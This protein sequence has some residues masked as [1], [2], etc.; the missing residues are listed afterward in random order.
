MSSRL[1]QVTTLCEDCGRPKSTTYA[2]LNDGECGAHD[3]PHFLLGLAIV[4]CAEI[5]EQRKKASD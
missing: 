5:A 1:D 2:R 3:A 4:E